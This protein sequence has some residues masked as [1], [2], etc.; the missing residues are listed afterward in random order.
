MK[1]NKNAHCNF[2]LVLRLFMFYKWDG[3]GKIDIWTSYLRPFSPDVWY[4]LLIW[5]AVSTV[6]LIV[7]ARLIVD[8]KTFILSDYLYFSMK[9]LCNQGNVCLL[10]PCWLPTA[11]FKTEYVFFK[12]AN[13]AI[14][15]LHLE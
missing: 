4:A 3:V 1:L 7:V 15:S 8:E 5:T 9:A 13:F 2:F 10:L 6:F 11:V 12:L 14:S